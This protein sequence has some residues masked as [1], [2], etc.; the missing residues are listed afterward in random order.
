MEISEYTWT[1]EIL[2]SSVLRMISLFQIFIYS[3][4]C[5]VKYELQSF[6]D[7]FTRYHQI[8]MDDNNAEKNIFITLWGVY[9]YIVMPFVLK[10]ACATYM[11]II[12]I[13]FH[14]IIHKEIE[15][16]VYD[17]VINSKRSLDH[18]DYL[19]KF[20]GRLH[21]YNLKLNPTKCESIFNLLKK[22]V[23]TKWAGECQNA[24]DKIKEYPIYQYWSHQSWESLCYCIYL[25]WIM[26]LD[27]Y[28]GSIIRHVE[29]VEESK[30]FTI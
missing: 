26:H 1:I 19:R 10:N 14:D 15:V 11:K 28:W 6:V 17:V 21:K 5:C 18:L 25:S 13:L 30:Q 20:F 2:T 24:F 16:Y 22:D 7:C 29:E 3:S 4:V 23:A 8:L 27:V 12:T 9:C